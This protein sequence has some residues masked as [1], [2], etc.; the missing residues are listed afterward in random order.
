MSGAASRVTA[1]MPSLRWAPALLALVY[2]GTVIASQGTIRESLGSHADFASAPVMAELLGSAAPDSLTTLGDY[3]WFEALWILRGT[4]W[5]PAHHFVWQLIPFGIWLLTALLAYAGT[6]RLGSRWAAAT[7]A[8][9]VIC[10]GVAARLAMWSLNTHGPAAFHVALVGFALA[11]AASAP[12]WQRGPRAYAA[13]VLVGVITALGATDPLVLPLAIA[14]LLAATGAV[15]IW[16]REPQLF[17]L[18]AIVAVVTVVGAAVLN[19]LARRASIGWTQREVKFI[20]AD[21]IV[22]QIQLI[23]GSIARLFGANAY[24]APVSLDNAIPM[25]GGLIGLLALVVALT[26]GVRVV[27][28]MLMPERYGLEGAPGE[29]SA[30]T[31]AAGDPGAE[32]EPLDASEAP[33]SATLWV[34][35]VTFWVGVIAMNLTAYVFTASAFELQG[36][37]YLVSTWVA[38]CVLIPVLAVRLDLRWIGAVAATALCFTG[39]YAQ[40]D[41]IA[42]THEG[43]T[44]SVQTASDVR[45]FAAAYGA[46][47]GFGSFWTAVPITW[48]TRFALKV[49]PVAPCGATNCRFHQHQISSWYAKDPAR[50]RSLFV[51]DTAMPA[52]PVIDPQYGKPIATAHFGT[53]TAYVF[54]GDIAPFIG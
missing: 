20:D 12:R 35:F 19:R 27:K 26:T 16:R 51:T 37:R 40:L 39:V 38:L 34:A 33:P 41:D 23:P 32:A 14:P 25:A 43:V 54:E 4:G 3:H 18:A 52:L 28:R 22:D 11:V 10:G 15:W 5:L 7:A 13:A 6:C 30:G 44:P 1:L 21:K 8:A 2:L 46:T 31:P 42:P 45:T 49:Y 17:R 9:L 36:A 24:G 29:P 47:S 53:V 50:R 48:H